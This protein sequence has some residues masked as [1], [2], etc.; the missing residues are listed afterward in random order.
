VAEGSKIAAAA[1]AGGEGAL[2]ERDHRRKSVVL[3]IFALVALMASLGAYLREIEK[4]RG[5]D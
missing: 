4:D 1:F 3:P 2:K 5:G